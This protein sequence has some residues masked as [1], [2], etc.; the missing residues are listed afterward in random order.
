MTPGPWKG[1]RR[2]LRFSKDPVEATYL[3]SSI[4][5]YVHGTEAWHRVQSRQRPELSSQ[6]WERPPGKG[7]LA[8]YG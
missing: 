7:C 3:P 1:S 2:Q 6:V 8:P 4:Y 5:M